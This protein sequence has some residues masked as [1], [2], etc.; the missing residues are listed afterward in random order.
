MLRCQIE[1]RND[2]AWYDIAEGAVFTENYN[3]TLDSGN[4]LI[5]QLP[6]EIEIEPYDVVIIESYGD[7]LQINSRRMCVDMV[8]CTQV[9]LIPELFKYEISLFSETK[10]LET[11]ICP[12]LAIT[13][14]AAGTRSVSYYLNRY[15]NLYSPKLRSNNYQGAYLNKFT[16]STAASQRFASITCPEMQWNQPTLRE[17]LNDLMMVDDCI[18]VLKNNKVEFIDISLIG[19]EITDE[20]KA[21]IN[22]VTK[23]HSSEDYV[24]DVKMHLVN[25]ANNSMS[26]FGGLP[27]DTTRIVERI[28]FR[29]SESYILTTENMR[30]QTSFPIWKI[31]RCVARVRFKGV[32]NLVNMED[33]ETDSVRLDTVGDVDITKYVLEHA[34][35]L[36]KD[37]YYGAWTNSTLYLD[38]NYQNKCLYYI[39]G[40]KNIENFNKKVENQWLWIRN[41]KY[42]YEMI[43]D[44]FAK[45][46]VD[47]GWPGW[48]IASIEYS[49]DPDSDFRTAEFT[50]EYEAIDDCV[51]SATKSPFAK[52]R[53]QIIDN[54]TNSYIDTNRQG[55]LEYLKANRLGNKML[56]ANGRY[57]TNESSMP[58][59]SS[60]T[61]A[62]KING[63]I[64]FMKQIS[65]YDK[66]ID[67]N[68]QATENYVLKDYFTGVK[69]KIRSWRVV[70]GSEALV[71]AELIKL[72]I[73][74]TMSSVRNSTWAIPV[75]QNL[76]TYMEKFLYC[77]MRFDD[78]RPTQ[79]QYDG[80]TYETNAVQVEFTK[81]KAGNS[82]IFTI[83]MPDNY[84]AGNY[85]SNYDGTDH[86]VEQKGIPYANSD[87]EVESCVIC[88]YDQCNANSFSGSVAG[89]ALKPLINAGLNPTTHDGISLN[90][91][92][93]VARIPVTINKDNKEILQISIQFELNQD[94]ND[95]F[96][97]KK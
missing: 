57:S 1:G 11:V 35:W 26:D 18:A 67:V 32:L 40:A 68:Y 45:Q 34:E 91:D 24:S 39:R 60:V 14:L 76:D 38:R 59:F 92:H 80:V 75:Y 23:T 3:E 25:A 48:E 49:L 95:I 77:A 63:S 84:Y 90:A 81:H 20:Q 7:G 10:L 86:R 88:F 61:G 19:S 17:V 13:K 27:N 71:R 83:R 65:V 28:G 64:V 62:P 82:V 55:L 70:S 43:L 15:I 30:L 89:R 47:S 21:S 56:Q 37:V 97:G 58:G 93:L 22:Y 53:R 31:F 51:F 33:P 41:S 42:V 85:V 36:T 79:T 50:L 9:S 54:Q 66:H 74:P 8:T 4:I 72:Y 87:G 52:N 69:S 46:Y 5:Q 2:N 6:A 29:N 73:N 12:N 96:L 44:M 94:A 16:I 78:A